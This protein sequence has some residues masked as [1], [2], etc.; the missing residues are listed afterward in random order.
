MTT[1]NTTQYAVNWIDGMNIS[2][3]NFFD[4]AN[5][6]HD[7]VRDSRA[8]HIQNWNYGLLPTDGITS[9]INLKKVNDQLA[10][11]RCNG[12]TEGGYRIDIHENGPVGNLTYNLLT[13]QTNNH[14]HPSVDMTFMVVV[15][16]NPSHPIPFGEIDTEEQPPR[17]PWTHPLYQL[18]VI[19]EEDFNHISQLTYLL[20]VGKITWQNGQF[21]LHTRFIPPS[22]KIC[23][24]PLLVDKYIE[25]RAKLS[26]IFNNCIRIIRKI[27]TAG[28]SNP[29]NSN[30][31]LFT[32]ELG[33]FIGGT[34]DEFNLIYSAKAP[35]HLLAYFA[36][37]TRIVNLTLVRLREE[38]KIINY[39]SNHSNLTPASFK[40][41]LDGVTQHEY[42]HTEII[43]MLDKIDKFLEPITTVLDEL[44]KAVMHNIMH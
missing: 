29:F 24:L 30:I 23:A 36:K 38:D 32:S 15:K 22:A 19:K 35:I 37:M 14:L 20:P 27:K 41:A 43:E 11:Y 39:I 40:A 34:F 44:N 25:Y 13:L 1:V 21:N 8:T 16:I 26:E 42:R 4:Q 12:I 7:T 5:H 9:P 6:F 10:L 17:H 28:Q 33:N 18:E 31:F 2:S 3:Q